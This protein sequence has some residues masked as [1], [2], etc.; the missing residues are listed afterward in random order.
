MPIK[1]S[2]TKVQ[3]FLHI[4]KYK[5]QNVVFC[6]K[7]SIGPTC[8]LKDFYTNKIRITGLLRTNYA[9]MDFSCPFLVASHGLL[10]ICTESPA[11]P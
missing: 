8:V 3:N 4:C 1:F 5:C 9:D 10:A 2:A 6:L 7:N 11:C